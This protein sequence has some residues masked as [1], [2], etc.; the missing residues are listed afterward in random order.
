MNERAAVAGLELEYE[1]RGSGEPVVLIH[2]GVSAAW[3]EPLVDEPALADRYRLLWYHRAGFAGS[4]R[5]EGPITMA[6]HANH[7]R[8]LMRHL[9]I[10]RAHVVGHSSSAVIA[11]QLALDSPGAVHTLALMEPARPVPPT[12][13]QAEFV[14]EFVA[15]AVQRYR[16]GDKAGAIDT[17]FRGAFGSDYGAALEQDFRAPS[18][19]PSR[20]RMRS[21]ARSCPP[22]S[23]GRSRRRMRVESRSRFSLCSGRAR[24]PASRSD[25]NCCSP[26]CRTSSPS[27]FPTR[28]STARAESP[29]HGRGP[30]RLLRSASAFSYCLNRSGLRLPPDINDA[31]PHAF[32]GNE[33]H[34]R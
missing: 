4:S 14:R 34:G 30:G 28:R 5:I 29:W 8:L 21:S 12:E 31:V 16:A 24:L 15:P 10:E 1:L 33:S 19:K 17:F 22:S 25:E 26:G 20:T 6:E 7:C 11:L 23:S 2:W 18:S 32:D 13:I 27:T 9:G 3:A